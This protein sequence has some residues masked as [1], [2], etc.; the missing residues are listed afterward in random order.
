MMKK[1]S[2][3]FTLIEMLVAISIMALFT[4]AAIQFSEGLLGDSDPESQLNSEAEHFIEL[5]RFAE[6]KTVLSGEPIGLVIVPP[7]DEPQWSYYWEHYRGGEWVE[8]P[9]PLVSR[10]L[11]EGLEVTLVIEGEEIDFTKVVV[12]EVGEQ[13][14]R[15]PF[16]I[17][18]PGGEVTPF[19]LTIYNGEDFQQ[20]QFLTSERTGQVEQLESEESLFAFFGL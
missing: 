11:P 14:K 10:E 3:G 15:V 20:Q 9:E 5:A 16:I 8:S 18:Y 4:I 2:T 13:Q 6:D 12:E 17:F 19:R 7:E 1:T